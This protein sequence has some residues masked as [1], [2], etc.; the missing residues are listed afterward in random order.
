MTQVAPLPP[1]RS[2][3]G[4]QSPQ[5]EYY[6]GVEPITSFQVDEPEIRGRHATTTGQGFDR[7]V[8]WTIL[9]SLVPGLGLMVAGRRT[10]GRVLIG[11]VVAAAL[12]AAALVLLGDPV[13]LATS[14]LASP[15]RL[16]LVAGGFAVLALLWGVLVVVTH[17][18]LRRYANLV[19]IALLALLATGA[20]QRIM[21]P[22]ADSLARI[23]IGDVATAE[24]W[25]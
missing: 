14:V 15:D 18:S 21:T 24:S 13:A 16:R 6:R 3:R 20:P 8:G 11:L 4:A 19:G 1:R 2:R 7:V 10:A 9:G 23:F 22:A 5:E 25:R 12:A 17:S